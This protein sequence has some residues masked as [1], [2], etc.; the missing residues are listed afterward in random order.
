MRSP[1]TSLAVR[2]RSTT[3]RLPRASRASHVAPSWPAASGRASSYRAATTCPPAS[4]IV[5]VIDLDSALAG[6]RLGGVRGG[7]R[8]AC[9]VLV[10]LAQETPPFRVL[11]LCRA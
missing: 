3:S 8:Q 4:A 10:Q 11:L 2:K 9:L 1:A 5:F 6:R 7:R